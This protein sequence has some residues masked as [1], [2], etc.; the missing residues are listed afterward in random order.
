MFL[1]CEQIKKIPTD[2][3]EPAQR[4]DV[5]RLVGDRWKMLHSPMHGA[6]HALD[7]QFVDTGFISNAEVRHSAVRTQ[8]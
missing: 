6:A 8:C 1:I 7:P 2:H 5:L 3:L 4:A